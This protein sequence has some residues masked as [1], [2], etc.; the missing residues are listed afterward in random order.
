MPQD[1]DAARQRER[2]EQNASEPRV[3]LRQAAAKKQPLQQYAK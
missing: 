3:A 1:E 2:R